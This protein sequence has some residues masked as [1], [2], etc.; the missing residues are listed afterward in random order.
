MTQIDNPEKPIELR[1]R[2]WLMLM[3]N[4]EGVVEK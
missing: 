1:K 3:R 4:S 2:V